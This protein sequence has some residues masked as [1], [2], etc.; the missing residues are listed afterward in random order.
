MATLLVR[1]GKGY[2]AVAAYKGSLAEAKKGAF[3][4]TSPDRRI[5]PRNMRL[6]LNYKLQWGLTKKHETQSQH[7]RHAGTSLAN[8]VG[9]H[10]G[11]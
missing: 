1:R 3:N 11:S 10:P 7:I 5:S 8:L 4:Q 6:K 9:H 2:I